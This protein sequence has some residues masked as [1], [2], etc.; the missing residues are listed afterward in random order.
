MDKKAWLGFTD[1]ENI[2]LTTEGDNRVE[3]ELGN[4]NGDAGAK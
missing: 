4:S 2:H 3:H 1:I